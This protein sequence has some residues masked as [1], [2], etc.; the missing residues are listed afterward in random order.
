M[1]K[2]ED[3]LIEA[4]KQAAQDILLLL[5]AN[6]NTHQWQGLIA[7]I[8]KRRCAGLHEAEAIVYNE[9]LPSFKKDVTRAT[10]DLVYD[11]AVEDCSK[12]LHKRIGE[13]SHAAATCPGNPQS[14][15]DRELAIIARIHRYS[16]P[17]ILI[18]TCACLFIFTVA[19]LEHWSFKALL[20][21]LAFTI[22]GIIAYAQGIHAVWHCQ[23]KGIK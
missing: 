5:N 16:W 21:F 6:C 10:E 19:L 11:D 14:N 3:K 9:H 22:G 17:L 4:D 8:A 2:T 23:K 13:I 12:S 20:V 15:R 18:F 1:M 7:I